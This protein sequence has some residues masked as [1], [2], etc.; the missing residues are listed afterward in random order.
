MTSFK[1]T[2]D[3]KQILVGLCTLMINWVMII[4]L[5]QYVKDKLALWLYS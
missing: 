1:M 3:I 2:D 5:E 4:L